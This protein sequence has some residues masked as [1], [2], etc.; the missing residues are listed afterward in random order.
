[1]LRRKEDV[2]ESFENNSIMAEKY[3]I[4]MRILQLQV[5]VLQMFF[6]KQSACTSVR[7]TGAAARVRPSKFTS[8]AC[9]ACGS[10]RL[11]Y[12]LLLL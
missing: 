4:E 9:D 8:P 3:R 1:M 12:V 7:S 11:F 2:R 6:K 5:S 10:A